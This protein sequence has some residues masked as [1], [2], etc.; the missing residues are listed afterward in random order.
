M[1]AS[2]GPDHAFWSKLDAWSYRDAALLLCGFDPDR[3]RGLGIRLD[4]R[5]VPAE[6]SEASK[7]YRILKSTADK[8]QP[9]VHP[10]TV[11][12]HALGKGL[13]L[14]GLLL[15]AVRERFSHERK[16]AGREVDDTLNE[17]D[18]AEPNPRSKQF[19]LR[20]IYVLAT[21]GYGLKLEMP[22]ND[23]RD[24]AAD[25]ERAGLALDRGTI[26]RYLREARQQ[27]ESLRLT[28]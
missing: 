12:E 23:A 21:Q 28:D 27:A 13:P 18:D 22:Y 19:L 6:F 17:P 24:I 5:E 14:P 20:L 16:R 8:S 26:A 25:A 2:A 4:G 11:I 3:V 15:E 1:E 10:F 7:V 9:T